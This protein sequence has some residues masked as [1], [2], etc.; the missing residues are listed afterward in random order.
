MA[1]C[2]AVWVASCEYDCDCAIN[3]VHTLDSHTQLVV[4]LDCMS[5]MSPMLARSH[6]AS[7]NTVCLTWSTLYAAVPS[8]LPSSS[9]PGGDFHIEYLEPRG[10]WGGRLSTSS[11]TSTLTPTPASLS[12]SPSHAQPTRSV[13]NTASE[14]ASAHHPSPHLSPVPIFAFPRPSRETCTSDA[15]HEHLQ[16]KS[17]AFSK[18]TM[19]SRVHRTTRDTRSP[20]RPSLMHGAGHAKQTA[21]LNPFPRAPRGR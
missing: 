12:V 5:G 19:P 2:M 13:E 16:P 18:I 4:D 6:R 8:W 10:P 3:Y 21:P 15:V 11:T 7:G 9:R 20:A 1:G 17:S 14:R